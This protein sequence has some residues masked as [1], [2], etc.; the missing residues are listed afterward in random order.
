VAS[1]C[2]E[3]RCAVHRYPALYYFLSGVKYRIAAVAKLFTVDSTVTAMGTVDDLAP[4]AAVR[5]KHE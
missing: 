5:T 4:L 1:E 2:R 3:E